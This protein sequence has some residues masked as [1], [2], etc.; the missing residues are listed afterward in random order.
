M[1]KEFKLK[2]NLLRLDRFLSETTSYSRKEL[3][4]IIRQGRVRIGDR[5]TLQADSKVDPALDTV[6]LDGQPV[7]YES[8]VYYMLNKPAGLITATRDSREKTVMDLFKAEGKK[9]LFP[10]GRLDKDTEGLLLITND[11]ALAH[12]MLSPARHVEKVY[13]ALVRTA[14]S[15]ADIRAF[16][17]GLQIEPDWQALPAKLAVLQAGEHPLCEVTITEGKF[18]QVKR[19]FEAVGNEVL[20]LKRI[21]MGPLV[22][23]ETL[24][25][26]AYRSLTREEVDSLN[27]LKPSKGKK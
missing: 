7:I 10:V 17:E 3:K 8:L 9:D 27:L 21:S 16:E 25:G 15:D 5:V 14:V 4:A 12:F 11:G 19:M 20:A 13:H 6:Y 26:G 22:L 24:A 2:S 23:D 1:S 18:H